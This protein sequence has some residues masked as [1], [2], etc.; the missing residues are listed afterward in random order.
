[1]AELFSVHFIASKREQKTGI[2]FT[3]I[4]QSRAEDLKEYVTRFNREVV[5]ITDLQDGVP[6]ATFLN[7]L[8]LGRFKS[9]RANSQITTVVEAL[10]RVQGLILA[11]GDICWG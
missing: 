6:Y 1:M 5:L 10:R 9:S 11:H 4:L 8:L 2:H 3:K 7:G